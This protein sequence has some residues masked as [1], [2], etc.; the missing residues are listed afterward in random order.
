MEEK[1]SCDELNSVTTCSSRLVALA[2]VRFFFVNWCGKKR[3]VA[4]QPK[5]PILLQNLTGHC[6]IF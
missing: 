1:L 2:V 3:V 5:L 6:R 4:I